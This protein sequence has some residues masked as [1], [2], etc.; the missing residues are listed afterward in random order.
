[1]L[2]KTSHDAVAREVQF[3]YADPTFSLP[4]RALIRAIEKVTGQPKLKRLYL[5]NQRNPV[6]GENFFAAAVRRLELDVRF[7]RAQL[8]KIPKTGP[9]VIVANHPYGVLDGVVIAWL[10]GLVRHDFVILTNAVL[11]HAPE[12]RSYLLPVDFA[13]TEEA[14]KTNLRTRAEARRLLDAGGCVIVFPAGGVS[15]SPDKLGRHPAMDAPWQPFT[16]QLIQRS[17]AVVVPIFFGGQNSRL[18]QVASHLNQTLRLSLIFKEVRDRIGTVLPLAIGDPIDGAEFA[19][20]ADRKAAALDLM[21]RTYALAGH[22]PDDRTARRLASLRSR[23][24]AQ[25]SPSSPQPPR[26]CAPKL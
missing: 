24:S 12:T 4:K 23:R 19:A 6:E 13:E 18:F 10:I 7:N 2:Q 26:V 22:L 17:K 5:E 14:M 25:P 15:T 8:E 16:V 11:L 3:T 20:A 21:Q 9:C 1:M